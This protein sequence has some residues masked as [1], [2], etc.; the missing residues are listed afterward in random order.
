[1]KINYNNIVKTISIGDDRRIF[2][3]V[4]NG[5]GIKDRDRGGGCA[6]WMEWSVDDGSTNVST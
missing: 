2:P 1:M 6:R 5:R 3:P 4:G